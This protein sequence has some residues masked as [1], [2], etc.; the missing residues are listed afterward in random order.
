MKKKIFLLISYIIFFFNNNLLSEEKDKHLKVGLLAPFSGQYKEI[1]DSML[2][3]IQIALNEI[4]DKNITVIPRDSGLNNKDKLISSIDEIKNSGAKIVIGPI[5]FED[6][7]FLKK[8]KDMVFISPSNIN[9]DISDNIISI[10]INLESQLLALS[11]FIEKQ[12][13][14]KT[15]VLI[16]DNENSEL[17]L[18]KIKKLELSFFKT[19]E[20]N[21]DPK[22]L[23]GQI[24]KLTNYSQRK[25]NLETRKKMLENKEDPSSLKELE[26]LEQRYTL[27]KVN[28]DS[29]IVIDYGDSLNIF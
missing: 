14:T 3:S 16:P 17:I 9:S 10:G 2:Y 15:L 29:V 21:S 12:K 1:G 7:S 11:N 22:I 19:F 25:R 5:T 23:T 24:E 4:N 28:F 26:K 27:G 13:K 8:Y 18:S 20:Y 6:L